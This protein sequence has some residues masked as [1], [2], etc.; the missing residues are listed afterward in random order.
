MTTP[1]V[2]ETSAQAEVKPAIRARA[3]AASPRTAARRAAQPGTQAGAAQVLPPA[4]MAR[5]RRRHRMLILSFLLLVILPTVL[6]AGYLWGIARDQ[7]VSSVGFSVRKEDS[8][9]ASIDMLGGLSQMVQSSTASDTD[10]LYDYLQSEDIVLRIDN[11]IDLRGKFSRVW[12]DDPVFAFNPSGTIED[13]AAHWRR[14]VKI[15]Y[16]ETTQLI[17]LH[18]SAFTPEDS[19]EI[20]QHALAESSRTINRLSDIARE[21]ATRFS[22]NEL[23]RV[24]ERLTDSRKQM[25]AFRIRTQLVD[26]SADLA[27]QMSIIG[28]LQAQLAVAQ[29]DLETLRDSARDSDPRVVQAKSRISAIR[30]RIELERE[31]FSSSAAAPGG[32]SYAEMMEEYEGLA[33]NLEFSERAFASAQAAYDLALAEAQRQSRYLAAHIE[34]RLSQSATMPD[35]PLAVATVFGVLLLIWSI[36]LLVYYSLRDRR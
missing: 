16:D 6:A 2:P 35:R 13:L 25:T 15:H 18:V 33:V 8:S 5:P 20:A 14:Q 29:I 24:Q 1:E 9:G 27:G 4:N 36:I 31:K 28:T 11:N 3:A 32:E 30:K 26:P 7:Y 17:T 34:P 22:R 10:I 21:D 19:L 23:Q 12:P